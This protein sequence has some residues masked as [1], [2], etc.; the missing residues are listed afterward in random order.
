MRNQNWFQGLVQTHQLKSASPLLCRQT[1]SCLFR[2]DTSGLVCGKL[3]YRWSSI[4]DKQGV[5]SLVRMA[6]SGN[7]SVV[8]IIALNKPGPP[9]SVYSLDWR[10]FYEV[11]GTCYPIHHGGT[12]YPIHHGGSCCHVHHGGNCCY[13][14][15]DKLNKIWNYRRPFL[16]SK[17]DDWTLRVSQR[18]LIQAVQAQRFNLIEE[19]L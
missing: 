1:F 15:E 8:F 3:N 6:F 11:G 7:Q 16:Q 14:L 18:Q 12:C 17:H 19:E 10:T 4:S 13:I 9:S 2:H 5:S